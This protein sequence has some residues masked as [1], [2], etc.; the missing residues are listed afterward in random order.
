MALIAFLFPFVFVNEDIEAVLQGSWILP[1]SLS[2]LQV[3][4]KVVRA[5]VMSF[6]LP[7]LL[8]DWSCTAKLAFSWA[9]EASLVPCCVSGFERSRLQVYFLTR[10]FYLTQSSPSSRSKDIFRLLDYLIQRFEKETRIIGYFPERHIQRP[11]HS[12]V[13]SRRTM[14][15]IFFLVVL[16]CDIP[17]IT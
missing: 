11:S 4:G 12:H 2:W 17:N 15:R 16:C 13:C 10:C 5:N 1:S 9:D 8:P 3:G 7:P 6:L 14:E